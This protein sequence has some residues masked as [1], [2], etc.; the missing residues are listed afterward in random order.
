[1]H[2]L[3]TQVENFDRK[4]RKILTIGDIHYRKAD[5]E[6]FFIKRRKGAR[7]LV[8]VEFALKPATVGLSKYL[9]LDDD[10]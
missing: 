6:R 10:K 5:V 3:G 4:N 2:W 8:K 1:M 7:S 9:E